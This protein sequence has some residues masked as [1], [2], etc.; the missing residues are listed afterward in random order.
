MANMP[1]MGPYWHAR[2]GRP[3]GG[4]S[5]VTCLL[6][7]TVAAGLIAV[8]LGTAA[9]PGSHQDTSAPAQVTPSAHGMSLAADPL[10]HWMDTQPD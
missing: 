6:L 5:A 9:Q 2:T 8:S 7:I 1:E 3:R 4:R 10:N